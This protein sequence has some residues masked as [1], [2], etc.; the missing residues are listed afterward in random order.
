VAKAEEKAKE[1]EK[2]K[3]QKAVAPTKK[4]GKDAGA[5][6]GIGAAKVEKVA[7]S[8]ATK[9]PVAEQPA[10][11]GKSAASAKVATQPHA[12]KSSVKGSLDKGASGKDRHTFKEERE[13]KVAASTQSNTRTSRSDG[14]ADGHQEAHKDTPPFLEGSG[15]TLSAEAQES[16]TEGNGEKSATEGKSDKSATKPLPG[17]PNPHLLSVTLNYSHSQEFHVSLTFAAPHTY[18][19]VYP[20]IHSYTHSYTLM[21]SHTHSH[22]LTHIHALLCDH[23]YLP[24]TGGEWSDGEVSLLL[25]AHKKAD[26]MSRKFWQNVAARVPN[27]YVHVFVH[28]RWFNLI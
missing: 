21:H 25:L 19:H 9:V 8:A 3:V 17:I 16:A 2:A 13:R 18:A 7:K 20:I 14:A 28:A 6:K 12:S 4:G 5:T 24:Y 23:F 27:R 22:T 11:K 10:M 15:G 26:P 1:E